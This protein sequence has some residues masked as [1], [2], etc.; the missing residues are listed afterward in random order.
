MLCRFSLYVFKVEP[1]LAWMHSC[2]IVECIASIGVFL[3]LFVF[4]SISF[5]QTVSSQPLLFG[6]PHYTLTQESLPQAACKKTTSALLLV[7][8]PCSQYCS[9]HCHDHHKCVR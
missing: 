6:G 8:V 4:L 2:Q 3:H 1:G 7:H 5:S 9:P